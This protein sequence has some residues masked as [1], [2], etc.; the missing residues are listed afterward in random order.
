[1]TI[2]FQDLRLELFTDASYTDVKDGKHT[3]K[4]TIRY[5]QLLCIS[6]VVRS[7]C[8]SEYSVDSGVL[9]SINL[10]RFVQELCGIPHLI[11]IEV[12]CDNIAATHVLVNNNR[13]V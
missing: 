12:H 2:L 13:S 8:E 3:G 10:Q 4:D 9:D 7:T 1:M 11:P 6:N 5:Y